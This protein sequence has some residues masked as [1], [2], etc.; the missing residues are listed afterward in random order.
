MRKQKEMQ[1]E[2]VNSGFL[3]KTFGKSYES[4]LGQLI[5]VLSVTIT[6]PDSSDEDSLDR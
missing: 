3:E 4:K 2:F 5:Y 1:L 6:L